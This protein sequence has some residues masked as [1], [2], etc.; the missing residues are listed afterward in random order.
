M[1]L[2]RS[3]AFLLDVITALLYGSIDIEPVT[4]TLRDVVGFI[5]LGHVAV[6]TV[7]ARTGRSLVV[8]NLTFGGAIRHLLCA[9][10]M[11]G[12]ADE[13]RCMKYKKHRSCVK[14]MG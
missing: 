7:L 6:T 8:Q 1:L 2:R 14:E 12:Q 9:Y 13:R 5:L 10:I 11:R 4:D 3:V